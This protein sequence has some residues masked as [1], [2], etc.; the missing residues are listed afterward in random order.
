[1]VTGIAF[2][3][4]VVVAALP[5]ILGNG[6]GI[7]GPIGQVHPPEASR[8]YAG[9]FFEIIGCPPQAAKPFFKAIGSLLLGYLER[10]DLMRRYILTA[11]LLKYQRCGAERAFI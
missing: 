5:G 10:Q 3:S 8:I 7:I 1:M 4:I 2:C 9:V 6:I 11:T